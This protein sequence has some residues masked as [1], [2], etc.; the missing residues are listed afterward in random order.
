VKGQRYTI[1][2]Q[3]LV[4]AAAGLAQVR[5]LEAQGKTLLFV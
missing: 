5:D 3:R 1:G 4:P 2:N